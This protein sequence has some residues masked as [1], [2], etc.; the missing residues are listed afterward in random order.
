MARCKAYRY[1]MKE[2]RTNGIPAYERGTNCGR[3]AVRFVRATYTELRHYRQGEAKF[4]DVFGFCKEHLKFTEDVKYWKP[5]RRA[6]MNFVESP[7]FGVRGDVGSIVVIEASLRDLEAEFRLDEKRRI[8]AAVKSDIKRKMCQRNT[9]KLTM[10]D[11][12]TLCEE[13]IQEYTVESV[14]DS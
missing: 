8:M 7:V 9:C 13:A 2:A 10:E 12:L 14:M 1:E 5:I 6:N 3:N 4:D 11:W